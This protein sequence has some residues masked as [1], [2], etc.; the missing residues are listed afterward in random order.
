MKIIQPKKFSPGNRDQV[1]SEEELEDI[2]FNIHK[3]N[4]RPK[5]TDRRQILI[6]GCF[7][8]F[9]CETVGILYCL[10]RIF[11]QYPGK[12]KIVFVTY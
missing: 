4:N 1:K 5:P 3:L 8:E 2:Q 11:Q 6:V 12:Y 10:P 7:S 9:G